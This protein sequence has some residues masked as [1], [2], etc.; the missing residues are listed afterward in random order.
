MRTCVCVR[1]GELQQQINA[2]F[3]AAPYT[4]G[5]SITHLYNSSEFLVRCSHHSHGLLT[6]ST[7]HSLY[8]SYPHA[9]Y[10]VP[11]QPEW[12]RFWCGQSHSFLKC[13]SCY[14]HKS[15]LLVYAVCPVGVAYQDQ[16]V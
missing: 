6:T 14:T 12:D 2:S 5:E 10:E 1:V 7:K 8:P 16:Y 13:N 15:Y 11:R 9:I 3:F 4:P